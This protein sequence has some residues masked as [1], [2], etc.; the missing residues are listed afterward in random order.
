MDYAPC[1]VLTPH[2]RLWYQNAPRAPT[3]RVAPFKLTY[4]LLYPLQNA[5]LRPSS[6]TLNPAFV[7]LT[8]ILSISLVSLHLLVLLL[9]K[10]SYRICSRFV[11]SKRLN[12]SLFLL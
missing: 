6:R 5:V 4:P 2:F 1:A 9:V 8:E 7:C 11:P 12:D 3:R 10:C